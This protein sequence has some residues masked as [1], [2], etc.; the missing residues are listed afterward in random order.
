MLK[1]LTILIVL[2]LAIFAYAI[3]GATQGLL[4]WLYPGLLFV[5]LVYFFMRRRQLSRKMMM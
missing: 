4:S 1:A 2:T 3:W 5:C